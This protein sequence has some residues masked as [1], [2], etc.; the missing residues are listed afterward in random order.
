MH[1]AKKAAA[2]RGEL[3]FPLPVGYVYDDGALPVFYGEP[4]VVC[5]TAAW[6][7][8][9]KPSRSALPR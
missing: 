6:P 5:T 4:A 2:A 7:A 3:R 8:T 9:T 1:G